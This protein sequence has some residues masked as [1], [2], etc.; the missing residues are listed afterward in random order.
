MCVCL[1]NF[2]YDVHLYGYLTKSD[3]RI[4]VY[5]AIPPFNLSPDFE[6]WE[7]REGQQ[8][9]ETEKYVQKRERN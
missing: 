4:P 6:F 1:Y 8:N 9:E 2:W 7:R 3:V 5:Y